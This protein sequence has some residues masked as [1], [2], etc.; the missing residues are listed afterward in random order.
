MAVPSFFLK[1]MA[2]CPWSANGK[3]LGNYPTSLMGKGMGAS[4]FPRQG[5]GEG[6][7]TP[8]SLRGE[9]VSILR[10]L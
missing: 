6:M 7:T 5:K 3:G 8:L 10:S 2:T 9:G 1:G 4:M